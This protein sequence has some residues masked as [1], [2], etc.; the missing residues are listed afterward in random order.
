LNLPPNPTP[1]SVLRAQLLPIAMVFVLPLLTLL[2]VGHALGANDADFVRLNEAH[3]ERDASL[4]AADRAQLVDFLRRNPLSV[5]CGSDDPSL[6]VFRTQV[7]SSCNDVWQFTRA[8]TAAR[9]LLALGLVATLL[10]A[11]LAFLARV[12][13]RAQYGA[14]VVGWR[15]MQVFAA[16]ETMAQGA[17]AVWLS[18]W[19]TAFFFH[20]YVV[21]LIVL[22]AVI[23]LVMAWGVVRAI[24]V[25]PAASARL[26]AVRVDEAR[27]P[28]LFAR[29][30][31]LCAQVGTDAPPNLLVGVDDNFFVTETAIDA[32]DG[33]VEGR[34]L[35]V[36][37]SLLRVLDRAEAD[38]VLAHE[39]GHFVGGDTAFTLRMGPRLAASQRYLVALAQSAPPVF[40]FMRAYF[41]AFDLALL[42]TERDREFA[43]DAV[44][45]RVVSGA[46]LARALFKIAAYAHYR[47]RVEAELFA[48]DQTHA[49]LAID[50]RVADG[51]AAYV[52][53]PDFA[54]DMHHTATPH[55]FDTHPRLDARMAAVGATVPESEYAATAVAP[56][57]DG[58]RDAVADVEALERRLWNEYETR[59]AAAHD[60]SLAYRYLPATDEERALVVKHFPPRSFAYGDGEIDL[61]HLGVTAPEWPEPL[62]FDHVTALQINERM[63]KRY[64]DFITR[65]GAERAV[66]LRRLKVPENEFIGAVA[67]YH[68]RH[69]AAR[70][71]AAAAQPST[72]AT[73]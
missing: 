46:A 21:K 5:A 37:L 45:A 56:A 29:V 59:F 68:D 8:R 14:Y 26:D 69:L 52:A 22:V 4:G 34:S 72:G 16:A 42:R 71:A 62:P 53:G 73:V 27:A 50:A 9:G 55:P 65:G 60:L 63:L 32:L 64:L 20:I 2:F 12:N 40:H 11:A 17:L 6:A 47:T 7:A 36:S 19:I 13:A 25:E 1:L 51:F 38:A 49:A 24:F 33:R 3:F 57:A 10:G 70:E 66:L 35:Y 41:T 58:W 61:D 18:F 30:R 48:H 15:A 23:A 54:A 44:A 28:A 67:R 39:M 31:E 43:A